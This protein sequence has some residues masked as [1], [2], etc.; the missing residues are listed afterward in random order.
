M[1][2][3]GFPL[4]KPPAAEPKKTTTKRTKPRDAEN[5]P[6][7]SQNVGSSK[8]SYSLPENMDDLGNNF[9]VVDKVDVPTTQEQP[10]Q[11]DNR[12]QADLQQ[13]ALDRIVNILEIPPDLVRDS[14]KALANN[15]D[16]FTR[17]LMVDVLP[18]TLSVEP[19]ISTIRPALS[20]VLGEELEEKD[21]TINSTTLDRYASAA[22]YLRVRLY[23]LD[24]L[25]I[26]ENIRNMVL[27]HSLQSLK[28]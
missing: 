27:E 7:L 2:K 10:I 12:T 26:P 14:Q 3:K 18:V 17:L 9:R 4:V 24:K 15:I 11:E 16:D 21:L 19:S 8:R 13:E 1:K 25:G 28:G 5:L 20:Q 22:A 23:L 6:F